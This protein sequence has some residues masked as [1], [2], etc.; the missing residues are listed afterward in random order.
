MTR[1]KTSIPS[2]SDDSDSD[3]ND[4]KPSLNDLAHVVKL[5]EDVC[6]KQKAQLKVLKPKFLSS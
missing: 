5:F 3:S 4:D 1:D 6:T 2:S